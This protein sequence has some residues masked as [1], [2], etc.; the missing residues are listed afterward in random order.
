MPGPVTSFRLAR[1]T[2]SAR[3][4]ASIE[5]IACVPV[6]P[7][8]ERPHA[9]SQATEDDEER[10]ERHGRA[11]LR[12]APRCQRRHPPVCRSSPGQ[13]ILGPDDDPFERTTGRGLRVGRGRTDGRP[14]RLDVVGERDR[15][16]VGRAGERLRGP[17]R[18]ERP[19]AGRGAHLGRLERD[20][21]VAAAA[22]RGDETVVEVLHRGLRVER[23]HGVLELLGAEARDDVRA[24]QH[25]RVAEG[26]LAAPH[27]GLELPGRQAAFAVRVGQRREARLADEV[28]LRRA[29]RR[30]VHLAAAD[31]RDADADRAVAARAAQAEP[32]A[33]VGE[34]LVG[35]RDRLLE[36]D[37]DAGRLVVVVL[38][39]D[40]LGGQARRFEGVPRADLRGD[41]QVE[42]P[43][44]ARHRADAGLDDDDR[45][46]RVGEAIVLGDD[47]E[48]HMEADGH[49]P[50]VDGLPGTGRPDLDDRC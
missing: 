13:E 47:T 28:C 11:A 45:V 31:D 22:L 26:D 43:L 8:S 24:H 25:E 23:Q 2:S 18:D 6:P 4:P 40:R 1:I 50:L 30:D 35:G 29:D 3:W 48:L 7:G 20:R 46:R 32:V 44:R 49:V 21:A 33:L 15:R 16:A 10:E 42:V 38:V 27:V 39:A 12:L 36:A 37:P 14:G 34:P 9:Q 19:L 17:D 5:L 41:E